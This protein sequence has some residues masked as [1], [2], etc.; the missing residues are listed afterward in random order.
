[1]LPSSFVYLAPRKISLIGIKF[2]IINFC[3]KRLVE[4]V[5]TCFKV[6]LKVI[7]VKVEWNRDR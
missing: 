2:E 3:F 1:M 5:V 7:W 6:I 4:I